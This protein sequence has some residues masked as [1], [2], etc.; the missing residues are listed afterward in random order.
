MGSGYLAV[1]QIYFRRSVDSSYETYY[2]IIH[3]DIVVNGSE[4][5]FST[6]E[7]DDT[8]YY[9]E[10]LILHEAGHVLGLGHQTEGIMYP[11]MSTDDKQITLGAFDLDLINNKYNSVANAAT[12]QLSQLNS[13]VSTDGDER[14]LL[15][16]PVSNYLALKFYNNKIFN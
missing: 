12:A 11:Y 5:N 6:D 10:T 8:T 16:L 7:L 13:I 9:L 3:A 2:E 14:V 4:F 15:Y 1:T